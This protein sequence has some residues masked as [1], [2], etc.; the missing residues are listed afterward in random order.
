MFVKVKKK[1]PKEYYEQ[2]IRDYEHCRIDL[3]Q[4]QLDFVLD[5]KTKKDNRKEK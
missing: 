1:A 5:M 4:Q 2:L 3:N